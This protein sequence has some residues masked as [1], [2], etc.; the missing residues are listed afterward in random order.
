MKKKQKKTEITL[1]LRIKKETFLYFLI[2]KGN[3]I[4]DLQSNEVSSE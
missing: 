3:K 2:K 4:K 1:K